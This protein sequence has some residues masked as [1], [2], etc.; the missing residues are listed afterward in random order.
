MSEGGRG[1]DGKEEVVRVRGLLGIE[2][3]QE[4]RFPE[5]RND[6]PSNESS[7]G[8][9]GLRQ[10]LGFCGKRAALLSSAHGRQPVMTPKQRGDSE[11]KKGG[12]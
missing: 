12:K 4:S 1:R 3:R 6:Q 11:S 9:G 2:P 8:E 7:K 10:G 5:G